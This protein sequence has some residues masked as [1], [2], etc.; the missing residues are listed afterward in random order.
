MYI[1]SAGLKTSKGE[2][3][4]LNAVLQEKVEYLL[5][6]KIYMVKSKFI[7]IS[8]KNLKKEVVEMA[9]IM[10][11]VPLVIHYCFAV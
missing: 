1:L 7:K 10:L 6:E 4:A 9:T 8:L 3:V 2:I 11:A 5:V